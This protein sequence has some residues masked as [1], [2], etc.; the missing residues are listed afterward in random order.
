VASEFTAVDWDDRLVEDF[1]HLLYL[2]VREDL[3]RHYD[4]TTMAVVDEGAVGH[5]ALVARQKGVVAGMPAARLVLAEFDARLVISPR[6]HD[7]D[8]VE[9]GTVLATIDGPARSL[10]T[11]E[12][13]VLNFVG[14]LSGIATLARRY[15]RKVTG[16]KAR[17][18]DTRKTTPG[19][20]RLE[21]YAVRIGGGWNHRQGLYDAVLI[22]DNHL[23]LAVGQH[24]S[25]ADA[26][27]RARVF[28]EHHCGDERGAPTVVEVEIDSLDQLDA[29]LD[30]APDIILLDNMRPSEL[31][32]AVRRRD[33]SGSICILEAS[34]SVRLETVA[35]IAA[36]GVDRISVGALTHSAIWLDVALDWLPN[37]VP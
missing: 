33:T 36:T 29:V 4:L 34:G 22:K 28:I 24:R 30:A 17:I 21:K 26:V 9:P 5:A 1:Q 10:L 12:R 37:A 14:R 19:W 31:A 23:A 27:R 6:H 25:P 7:G 16:T 35:E 13:L 8:D 20:R 2:A 32:E 3:G 15:V 18:Y 11:A